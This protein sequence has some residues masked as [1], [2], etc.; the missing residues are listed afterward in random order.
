MPGC[1]DPLLRVRL[2]VVVREVEVAEVV[3][4]AVVQAHVRVVRAEP[5]ELRQV[6]LSRAVEG[7]RAETL[8]TSHSPPH[9]PAD[10][11]CR[12]SR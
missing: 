11:S 10:L 5:G 9:N 12:F 6:L 2:G 3:L 1:R 8:T 7:A 4:A